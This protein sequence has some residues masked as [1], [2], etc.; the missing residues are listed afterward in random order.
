MP[1]LHEAAPTRDDARALA[2]ALRGRR[3]PLDV[4]F[5][6]FLPAELREVS[7]Q[8]WT[9]L[10][11]VRQ[12]AR[13]LR[14]VD[15]RTVV[16]V[17]SGAGKFCV[18]AALMT[19]CRFVGLEQRAALV[20]A[21]RELADA[22]DVADR[23]TFATGALAATVVPAADAYYLFNPFG[24]YAFYS[25]RFADDAVRF[26]TE[27]QASDVDAAIALLAAAR[28]GTFVITLN[29][30]GGPMPESYEQ[31]EVA[32]RLPGTLRLWKQGRG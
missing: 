2:A 28:P 20:E 23:V 26:T 11:A 8:Y 9:P 5:D 4:A 17:G 14:E 10:K 3:F 30:I 24:E 22:F 1:S 12:A 7:A 16:D 25:R 32:R 31:L 15:A 27:R 19:R 21:A 29:G 13:W 18:A 6:R